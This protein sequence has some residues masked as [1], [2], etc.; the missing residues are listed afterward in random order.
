MR[1]A[2][3]CGCTRYPSVSSSAISLR[4][5]A[6]LT[7][8]LYFC[9][10]VTEPTGSAVLMYSY[11][12]VARMKAFRLSSSG[13]SF[14]AFSS[15]HWRVLSHRPAYHGRRRGSRHPGQVATVGDG[16]VLGKHQ[17]VKEHV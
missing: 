17:A 12:T 7:P 6:E 3:V 4:I 10:S 2:D 13:L 5:V 8:R 11:T 15:Q 16:D 14:I 9:V 1:P